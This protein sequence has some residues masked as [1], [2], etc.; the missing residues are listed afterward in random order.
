MRLQD[1]ATTMRRHWMLSVLVAALVAAALWA[2]MRAMAGPQVDVRRVVRRDFVESVVASGHVEAPHRLT[3]GAQGVGQVLRVP[4]A[5]GQSVKAGQVLVELDDT[6]LRANAAQADAAVAQAVARVRQVSEV[7]SPVAD[8]GWRQAAANLENARAQ[9]ERDAALFKQGFIGPAAMDDADKALAVAEAQSRA[10]QSQRRASLP[11]GSAAAIAVEGL[12]QAR[13]AA[14]AARSRLA[15]ATLRAPVAGVLLSRNVEPGDVVQPGVA[16]M[17]LS[18][19]GPTQLVVDIDEKNLQ[20]LA[21]GQPA[22]ASADAFADRVF[23][24]RVAYVNPGV[25]LQ[26][27]TVEVKLDVASPPPWL[28]QDMTVSVDIQVALRRQAVIVP[29]D[30]VQDAAGSAPWVARIE[31]RRAHRQGVRL[32]LRGAEL[33]EVLGGLADGDLV[34]AGPAVPADGARVRPLVAVR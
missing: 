5:E 11:S 12:A 2:A 22:Q 28:R 13:S 4:V 1:L 14:A 23:E 26:R 15:N 20:R 32:G 30:A 18:P 33:A 17:T 9:R 10:A 34:A 24:A 27:G 25:D 8:Q 7:D 3:I 19:D 31:G 29:L 16:L 21:L 6:E